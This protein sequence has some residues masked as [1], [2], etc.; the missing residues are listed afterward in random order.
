MSLEI[1]SALVET[2]KRHG[3]ETYPHECCGFLLGQFV[4]GKKVVRSIMQADNAHETAS[5]RNRFLITPE[6]YR[7]VDRRAWKDGLDVLGFY[8]SH[9]DHPARPSEYDL[10]QGWPWYSYVIVSVERREAK[11]VTSWVMADDRSRFDAETMELT[12]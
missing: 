9:P 11:D 12:K 7:A 5:Q 8:H 6:E 2:V 4:D 10:E 1:P 3:E